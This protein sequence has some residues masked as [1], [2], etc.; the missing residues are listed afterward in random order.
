MHLRCGFD[1]ATRE[2]F[3]KVQIADEARM[4]V[5][6]KIATPA[7]PLAPE[8]GPSAGRNFANLNRQQSSASAL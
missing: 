4:L 1:L 5:F 2:S 3:D 6:L 7:R 8:F